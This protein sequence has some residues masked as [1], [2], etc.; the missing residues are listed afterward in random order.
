MANVRLVSLLGNLLLCTASLI[1]A[2]YALSIDV[3]QERGTWMPPA[4]GRSGTRARASPVVQFESDGRLRLVGSGAWDHLTIAWQTQDDS[5]FDD[6]VGEW[7]VDNDKLS[8]WLE[9]GGVSRDDVLLEPGR[10]FGTCGA[11]GNLLQRRGTLTIKQRKFG[12]MPFLPSVNEASF[13][14]GTFTSKAV[15]EDG[16]AAPKDIS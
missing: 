3:G 7:A 6:V 4:W 16:P 2:R 5:A 14:V 8:F 11:W 15:E 9:H 13:I 12:W 10:I 1:D